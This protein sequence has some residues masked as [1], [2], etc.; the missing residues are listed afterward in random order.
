MSIQKRRNSLSISSLGID[1]IS[2]SFTSLSNGLTSL[3]EQTQQ[4]VKETRKLNELKRI[5][6]KQDS[7]FFRRRR[8]NA[9]RRERE[10]Q[11]EASSITGAQKR[12][13]NLIQ[14]STK[15]FLGRI[16]DFIGTLIIG[17]AVINLPKII[18]A[19]Q[20]LFKFITRVV[21]IFTKF[22]DGMKDFFTSIGDGV[23][24]VFKKLTRFDFEENTKKIREMFDQLTGNLINLNKAFVSSIFGFVNDE[25]IRKA[26]EA[27]QKLGINQLP[28]DKEEDL[29]AVLTQS[30]IENKQKEIESRDEGGNVVEGESYLIGLNPETGEPDER[31]ETFVSDQDGFILNNELTQSLLELEDEDEDDDVDMK[32]LQGLENNF[33]NIIGRKDQQK[34]ENKVTSSN[35]QEDE[36]NDEFL[37]LSKIN[38]IIEDLTNIRPLN[39]QQEREE[40][41]EDKIKVNKKTKLEIAEK[42][43]INKRNKSKNT[44]M[45]IEK[46]VIVNSNSQTFSSDKKQLFSSLNK[47]NSYF[48]QSLALK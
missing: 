48:L 47:D 29:P 2:K 1:S 25:N 13:G 21:T 10:D 14:R 30:A 19:F 26:P 11:L 41:A 38:K 32:F 4:L 27:A 20:K 9:R 31:T 7:E 45:V 16:L 40:I 34:Q 8:E 12:E 39:I 22:I 24:G 35:K 46:P 33:Q 18:E 42:S 36:D 43:I 17:W 28:N 44:V 6:I 3:S 23:Q 5:Q 15:G 37:P